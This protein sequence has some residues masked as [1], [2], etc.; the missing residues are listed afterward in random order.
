MKIKVVNKGAVKAKP[1]NYCTVFVDDNG[2][3][4]EATK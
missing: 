1:S 2:G 3:W 4:P